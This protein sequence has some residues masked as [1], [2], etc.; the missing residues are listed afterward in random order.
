M[1]G[2]QSLF[3]IA[4]TG[5]QMMD[6]Q[7]QRAYE[8][9]ENL[10]NKRLADESVADAIARGNREA[11]QLKM[12]GSQVQAQAELGYQ[13][14]GVDPTVGTPVNTAGQTAYFTELDAKTVEN[15]AAREAWGFKRT[16]EQ[17]T[18]KENREESAHNLKQ[19]GTALGG[20]SKAVGQAAGGGGFGMGG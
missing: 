13:A 8:Q 9:E 17:L 16:S 3:T 7:E 1:G 19:T 4:Q 12:K 5:V 15:N 11:G 20:I 6:Q 14:S 18:R 2:L 10:T